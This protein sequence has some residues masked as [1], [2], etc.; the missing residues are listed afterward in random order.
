MSLLL[1][2]VFVF[3]FFKSTFETDFSDAI[4]NRDLEFLKKMVSDPANV[5]ECRGALFS[6]VNRG[7]AENLQLLVD[8]NIDVNLTK[9]NGLT[10]LQSAAFQGR[11]DIISILI[12]AKA[13]I[14]REHNGHTALSRACSEGYV[15]VV[16]LLIANRANVNRKN[17]VPID[18][19]HY[20]YYFDVASTA[21]LLAVRNNHVEVVRLLAEARA[22][23]DYVDEFGR[24]ALGD[25]IRN[26]RTEVVKVLID[27]NVN[28]LY[29]DERRGKY[30]LMTAV[31]YRNYQITALLLTANAD[32]NFTDDRFRSALN[33]A[34]DK[35]DCAT[36]GLLVRHG[37]DTLS[38]S[39]NAF[40]KRYVN[41]FRSFTIF[42]NF[43]EP[44]PSEHTSIVVGV[45]NDVVSMGF[46][47]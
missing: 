28:V 19:S 17:N 8:A 22:D 42:S 45:V 43:V 36:T 5:E 40:F 20:Y 16:K 12:N 35:E 9:R 1:L 31:S 39:N 21:L 26:D 7:K 47:L 23:L 3:T 41:Y 25:A 44:L 11:A 33:I 29:C 34:V 18:L 32:V 10:A 6:A 38:V 13:E 4:E 2:T 37:A 27:H 14:D 30:P 15:D 24:F 46:D